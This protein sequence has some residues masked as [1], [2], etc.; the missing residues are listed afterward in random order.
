MMPHMVDLLARLVPFHVNSRTAIKT[1][2]PGG[3]VFGN[4]L[5]VQRVDAIVFQI[6][7]DYIHV[8]QLRSANRAFA[9]S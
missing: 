3:S 1:G 2:L 7:F 8:S 4:C 6:S 5:A 9:F